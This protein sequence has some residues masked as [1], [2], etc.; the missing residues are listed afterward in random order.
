MLHKIVIGKREMVVAK[1]ASIGRQW[2]GV[3]R[4]EHKMLHAVDFCPFLDGKRAPQ[5]K[6]KMLTMLRESGYHLVGKLLPTSPL[7]RACSMGAHCERGIE[8]EHAL[9]CPAHEIAT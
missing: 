7:M 5:Y 9:P 3:W 4:C 8:Q 2:R 1:K 6:H